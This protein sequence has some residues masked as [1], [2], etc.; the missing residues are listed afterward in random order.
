M[1]S[2]LLSTFK[3][4]KFKLYWLTGTTTISQTITNTYT[5][6]EE[7]KLLQGQ[8]NMVILDHNY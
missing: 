5:K 6:L 1:K 4:S 2:S 3:Y 8:S 7:S